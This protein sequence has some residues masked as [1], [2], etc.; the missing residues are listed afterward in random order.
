MNK[1]KIFLFHFFMI[2]AMALMG[3]STPRAFNLSAQSWR[4]W[5]D[6]KAPWKEDTLYLPNEVDVQNIKANAPGCGWK[7]I[8]QTGMVSNLPVCVEELFSNGKP[9]WTY[10]GVSWFTTQIEVPK[11]WK[12]KVVRLYIGKKNLRIE[13][14]I[15]EKLAGYDII[16]G[17]PYTCDISSYLVPGT[18]NRIAFRITNPGGQRGWNDFPLIVWGNY[19]FPPHRDFGGIGGEVTLLVTDKIFIS[20]V[21]VKNLLPAKA[22]NIEV[23][24]CVVNKTSETAPL[25]MSVRIFSQTNNSK[26]LEEVFDLSVEKQT[27]IIVKKVFQVPE[28]EIWDVD[29]PNLYNCEI[30]IESKSM[31][32]K[33]QQNFGFR[34]FEVRSNEKGEENYYLNGK[35][36]RHKSAI[37]WGYYA[38]HGY[39]PNAEM[40]RKSVEAAKAIGHN[41]INCHRN[42]G[43]Y[44]L[45][46]NADELGL[47]IFEEPGGF[48][49]TI[50]FYSEANSKCIKTFEGQVMEERCMRMVKRDRNH[51]SV[52]AY[53]LANERDIFDILRKNIMVDMHKVDDS[54]LIVNQSGGVPGGPSGHIPHLR[55]YDNKFR[56]DYMDDH[57]VFS[58]SR[59]M[60]YDFKS[61]RSAND[62]AK[63][64]IYGRIDP[65]SHDNI[66][67]WGEVRCYAGPD[68]WYQ[69]NQQSSNLPSNRTGYDAQAFRPLAQ[70]I[71]AYF[72]QNNLPQ[73]GSRNI[74]SPADVTIQ[75]GRGLM[76]I[77]GRLDQIIL[78]NNSADGF[79]INGW[80]GGT[81]GI[82]KEHGEGMEWY[83]AI[84]DE[85]RNLKG[86][87]G[88]YKY[89][90]RPLQVAIF[91]KNG[92]YF[93]PGQTISLEVHLIN[94]GKLTPGDYSLTIRV[95]DGDGK[96]TGFYKTLSL[97]VEGGDTY[98]QL[99]VPDL[100]IVTEPGWKAGYITIEGS[101]VK[102]EEV[103]ATGAE[104]VLLTN[105]A[106]YKSEMTGKNLTV[107]NWPA[108]QKALEQAGATCNNE[109]PSNVILAGGIPSSEQIKSMLATAKKGGTLI[110]KFDGKWAE[111][112][113]N[114]GILKEKVTQWGG[115]QIPYWIG[116]GWGYIDHIIG[117]QAIPGGS[118]IGTNS[119][120]VPSDPQGFYPFVSN[121][122]QKAYGAWF[123]RPD[124]LLVLLGEISF[125]KGKI[126]LAPSYPV[127]ANEAFNDLLFFNLV[128]STIYE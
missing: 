58:E 72:K 25:I 98:A 22:N 124:T 78:K 70:K 107:L 91:R 106:S 43:D 54:K 89:W 109:L 36:F 85:G 68:N 125:G 40:A 37:D 11:D 117:N 9:D 57:T 113:Y 95:K 18:K 99:I 112:L 108:A 101:V 16:G 111:V 46:K 122:P 126:L 20:D 110:L 34:V 19:K 23:Q 81:S 65:L 28:A 127:E 87:P 100:N 102:N 49:E 82:P 92:K 90:N 41:G 8:Y 26:V 73:T 94:E 114:E 66:I 30:T 62:T 47:V 38:H 105:R 13:I 61:H 103:L 7:E 45:L 29:H 116:N 86:F 39:Y 55:P 56:L 2:Y 121:Y 21:F 32:D 69:V 17:T 128:K 60:E 35:R 93:I 123:A 50:K 15:N 84:V 3:Q 97:K 42:M 67:Y 115:K 14:Y 79:A 48:D 96:Q 24:A 80:S 63:H 77:D 119:W 4:V 51:P 76:Y 1:L 31:M 83:S 64:G 53:I 33:A 59:F 27:E 44:L 52:V 10:H 120:E 12:D 104:Q 118:T 6:D 74:Q 5:L 71:E 75:A 88:D